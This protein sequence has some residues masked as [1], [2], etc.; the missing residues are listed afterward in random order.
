MTTFIC[1]I[2]AL[3]VGWNIPQPQWAKDIQERVV[4]WFK[5]LIASVIVGND[6]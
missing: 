6:K 3:F 2:V 4:T 1:T 5:K